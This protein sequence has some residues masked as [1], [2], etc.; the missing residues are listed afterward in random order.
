MKNKKFKQTKSSGK[1]KGALL[2]ISLVVILG[3]LALGYFKFVKDDA[4][5]NIDQQQ[6]QAE[7]EDSER[8]KQEA[9]EALSAE[10]P[11]KSENKEVQNPTVQAYQISNLSFS[12]SGGQIRASVDVSGA[13]SGTCVF[14]FTDGDGRAI[15]KNVQVADKKCVVEAP[16]AEF[17]MIGEYDLSV[18]LG[19]KNLTKKV[20]VS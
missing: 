2:G 13:S 11:V 8:A 1:K 15:I 7:Q 5:A 6:V 16:E 3:G 20:E 14:T 18:K 19:E 9:D 10:D 12:Q 17:T 4:P